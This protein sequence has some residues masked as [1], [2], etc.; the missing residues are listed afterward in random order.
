MP[1]GLP[2]LFLDNVDSFTY[3]LVDEF[4]KRGALVT[5]VRND[6]P[7]EAVMARAE[8]ARLL[9]VSP[10]PGTPARAGSCLAVVRAALG[11]I[12]ILGVCL[13]HQALV[14]A[15]GGQVAR[16]PT[17]VHGKAVAIQHEGA[18]PFGR[19]PSPMTVGRY[20]SL[21][22]TEVPPALEVTAASGSLVMAVSHRSAP[23]LGIQFHP[24]S[25]L[26]PL[27]GQLIENVL[28]WADHGGR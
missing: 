6:L 15:T 16:A 8:A 7:A 23:A 26:T 2:V 4:G 28:A 10:G 19:L 25:I 11:R 3:N 22:A 17:A 12:P 18:A 13:G 5:V 9:V 14:E 20:H 1:N 24:E 27:G 21:A